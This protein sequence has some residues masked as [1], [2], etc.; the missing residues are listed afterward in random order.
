MESFIR[1]VVVV[2]LFLGRGERTGNRRRVANSFFLCLFM[3]WEGL[4]ETPAYRYYFA[5]AVFSK[6]ISGF[7]ALI[8]VS[9]TATNSASFTFISRRTPSA[10]ELEAMALKCFAGEQAPIKLL[11]MTVLEVTQQQYLQVSHQVSSKT[12]YLHENTRIGV[13]A[14]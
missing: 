4:G 9:W 11:S 13:I 1:E 14:L 8:G 7:W 2:G 6:E 12:R 10:P 5:T 3:G